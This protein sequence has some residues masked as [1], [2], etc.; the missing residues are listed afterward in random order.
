MLGRTA[1]QRQSW[2]ANRAATPHAVLQGAPDASGRAGPGHHRQRETSPSSSEGARGLQALPQKLLGSKPGDLSTFFPNTSFLPRPKSV[3]LDHF[4]VARPRQAR[5][6]GGSLP[7]AAPSPPSQAGLRGWDIRQRNHT[8]CCCLG[9]HQ[10][11]F[12]QQQPLEP[13]VPAADSAGPGQ[14]A[15]PWAPRRAVHHGFRGQGGT[16]RGSR[17]PAR[18]GRA[19]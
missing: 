19:G 4:A 7:E 3:S 17:R 12:P 18:T 16:A 2:G 8:S 11:G 9:E 1:T 15:P 13:A 5:G 10:S 14:P 6:P